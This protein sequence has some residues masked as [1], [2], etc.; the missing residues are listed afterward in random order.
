MVTTPASISARLIAFAW[1]RRQPERLLLHRGRRPDDRPP[2]PPPVLRLGE[3]EQPVHRVHQPRRQ[4]EPRRRGLEGRQQLPGHRHPVRQAVEALRR[5]VGPEQAG[6][7][8]S[9]A[10]GGAGTTFPLRLS[11]AFH[12]HRESSVRVDRDG[13]TSPL[14]GNGNFRLMMRRLMATLGESEPPQT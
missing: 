12:R 5:A 9:K 11:G 1:R 4:A 3:A 10:G 7:Q 8:S 13:Q 6:C 2:S 14:S